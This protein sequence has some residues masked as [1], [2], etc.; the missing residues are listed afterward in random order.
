MET[1]PGEIPVQAHYR[2]PGPLLI[3][4][5]CCA[6][7]WVASYLVWPRA[8]LFIAAVAA[9]LVTSI[10]C[11]EGIQRRLRARFDRSDSDD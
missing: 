7:L 5:A 6:V 9:G 8:T 1:P 4:T 11:H 2:S 3:A 10:A